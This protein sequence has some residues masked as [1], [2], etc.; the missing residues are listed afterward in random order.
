VT[1]EPLFPDKSHT[2]QDADL[3]RVL[4]RTKRH[5]DNITAHALGADPAA[6]PKWTYE[7]KKAGWTLAVRGKRRNLLYLK[8]YDKRF[9][10]GFALGKDAVEAAEQSDLPADVIKMIKQAPKYPEGRAV[11]IEV[12]TAA[13]V[14]LAKKLL[15]LKMNN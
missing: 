6:S 4:G 2:P 10:V 14:K 3:A 15:A 7:S 13:D 11:R 5:W 12:K 8:P 9:T 1:E